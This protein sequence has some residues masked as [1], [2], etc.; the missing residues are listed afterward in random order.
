MAVAMAVALASATAMAVEPKR[1]AKTGTRCTAKHSAPVVEVSCPKGTLAELLAT[2]HKATGLRA[3]YPQELS[4]TPV[5]VR[6]R[7]RSLRE[8]VQ[9]AL[10]G[11]NFALW[12][13]RGSPPVT[14]LMIVG[15]RGPVDGPRQ[16][17]AFGESATSW[18]GPPADS[19]PALLPSP[20]AA[21]MPM[22]D[23]AAM[24][25]VRESF[26]RSV[27]TGTATPK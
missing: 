21:L 25:R 16:P 11:F 4:A 20:A 27:T 13:E 17:G 14:K 2:L 8:A 26:A 6:L 19:L 10:P 23:E 22:D 3:Q 5:S 1:S 18:D 7:S 24:A 15:I 12:E 9:A